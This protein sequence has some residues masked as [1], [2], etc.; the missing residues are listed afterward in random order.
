MT[1]P[2]EMQQRHEATQ[3]GITKLTKHDIDFLSNIIPLLTTKI[4][5]MI[6]LLNAAPIPFSSD[7]LDW[8]E[9]KNKIIESIEKLEEEKIHDCNRIQ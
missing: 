4:K 6:I 5:E 1:R 8:I 7:G 9:Q 2:E 3:N